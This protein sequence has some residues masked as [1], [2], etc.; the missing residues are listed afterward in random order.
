MDEGLLD[1]SPMAGVKLPKEKRAIEEM[2]WL[3][4]D[5]KEMVRIF[6]AVDDVW[7][8][9][10]QG[11]SDERRQ[12][13]QM[14]IRVL[15]YTSMRPAEVMALRPDQVDDRCIRVEGGKTKSAWRVIPLHPRIS[16]FPAWVKA[17]GL[18]VFVNGETGAVQSDP[19]TPIRHNFTR[20]IRNKMVSPIDHPRKALYSLRST[21]QNALRRAG[22]PDA[23][24]RAILGHVESG[25]IRHYNDGPEFEEL[26]KWIERADPTA[27][28]DPSNM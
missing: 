10:T 20:L 26:R 2:K 5:P 1:L 11:I 16:D 8:K 14:V 24:R 12:A 6:E 25:A 17:G 28:Y 4:F 15:S 7:G 13:L 23:V 27:D 19:V 18:A 22:A 21:F 3:P 9:P